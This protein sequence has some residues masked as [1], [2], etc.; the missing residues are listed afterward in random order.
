MRTL[1]A[2]NPVHD[3]RCWRWST[4]NAIPGRC[5][6]SRHTW[7]EWGL[8]FRP[9]T[10]SSCGA[11]RAVGS[12]RQRFRAGRLSL[13]AATGGVPTA[14][15]RIGRREVALEELDLADQLVLGAAGQQKQ[16]GVKQASHP[17]R[18]PAVGGAPA[19]VEYFWYTAGSAYSRGKQVGQIFRPSSGRAP[20][21]F[22]C[23]RRTGSGGTSTDEFGREFDQA[24]SDSDV[25]A[26]PDRRRLT[27]RQ[28]VR[29]ARVVAEIHESHGK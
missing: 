27:G 13:P 22:I 16:Q 15:T 23:A 6:A 18:I 9:R 19:G 5:D 29:S 7:R 28:R 3:E 2:S 24:L 14:A 26:I 25:K 17:G 10:C 4:T 21:L 1:L 8:S 12:G 11:R 20:L